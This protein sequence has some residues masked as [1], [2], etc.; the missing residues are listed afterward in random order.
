MSLINFHGRI[1]LVNAITLSVYNIICICETWINENLELAELLLHN[2]FLYSSD[3]KLQ[4]D[5]TNHG[6]V[7]VA[8]KNSINCS[9]KGKFKINI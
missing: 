4:K 2:N 6:S 9:L 5:T 7:I 3:T 1:K 8:K